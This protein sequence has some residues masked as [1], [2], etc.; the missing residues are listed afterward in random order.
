VDADF[1]RREA[2]DVLVVA[3]GARPR[4]PPLELAGDPVVLDAWEVLRGAAVPSGRVVVADWRCDWVGLGLS[5]LL[6][7]DGHPVVLA[8]TGY[9]AGFRVQQY[10]RDAMLAA[11]ARTRVELRPLTRLFGYDGRAVFLQHVLTAEAV[12]VEE[13]AALV[14]ASGHDPVDDL[15]AP[16]DGFAGDVVGVGDCLAPRTVEEAVLEGLRAGAAM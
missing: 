1:V 5:E 10:V 12:I 16:I 11:V 9:T 15:L 7:R 6:A 3:T 8:S 4:R 13:V 14:L 2:P